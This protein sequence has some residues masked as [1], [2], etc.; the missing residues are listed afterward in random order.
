MR[1]HYER[2]LDSFSR[3]VFIFWSPLHCPII[4]NMYS[5]CLKNLR[6]VAIIFVENKKIL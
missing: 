2:S 3:R 1:V 6:S 5:I 4:T